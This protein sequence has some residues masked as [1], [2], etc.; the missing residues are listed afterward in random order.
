MPEKEK[1]KVQ[2]VTLPEEALRGVQ[3][4]ELRAP[5]SLGWLNTHFGTNLDQLGAN[6]V[7][8][9][10]WSD[11]DILR[12]EQYINKWNSILYTNF[13]LQPFKGET[14]VDRKG[15]AITTTHSEDGV[16]YLNR[17]GINYMYCLDV[18]VAHEIGHYLELKE[19][20][21]KDSEEMRRFR[22]TYRN[23]GLMSHSTSS[24]KVL[25][26]PSDISTGQDS[27]VR[28][29]LDGL[30]EQIG[31]NFRQINCDTIAFQKRKQAGLEL[32]DLANQYLTYI[33]LEE[34]SIDRDISKGG[35]VRIGHVPAVA[36][37]AAGA[38]SMSILASEIIHDNQLAERAKESYESFVETLKDREKAELS[39]DELHA[40]EIIIRAYKD[41]FIDS[42]GIREL[43]KEQPMEPHLER[44]DPNKT[45]NPLTRSNELLLLGHMR[46]ERFTDAIIGCLDH[47]GGGVVLYALWTLGEIGNKKSIDAIV[48]RFKDTNKEVRI[49]ALGSWG[50]AIEANPGNQDI[51]GHLPKVVELFDDHDSDLRWFS[52]D[53]WRS[54]V[55]ANPGNEE[56]LKHLPKLFEHF[57]D[58][59]L[60]V[61]TFADS[62]WRTALDVNSKNGMTLEY[63]PRLVKRFD[64]PDPNV[65]TSALNAWGTAAELN[66]GSRDILD[67]LPEVVKHF[68]D[69]NPDIQRRALWAWWDVAKANPGNKGVL[70]YIP[71]LVEHFNNPLHWM[72]SDALTIYEHAVEINPSNE[73]V[74]KHV[75]KAVECFNSPES[76]VRICALNVWN[77]ATKANPEN[78]EILR[79]VSRVVELFNDTDD[80]VRKT[81]LYAWKAAAKSNPRSENVLRHLPNVLE[82]FNDPD[83]S[84]REIALSAWNTAAKTSP[85]NE[86]VLRGVPKVIE[87]FTNP[88]MKD[89]LRS[90]YAI[91]VSPGYEALSALEFVG[92]RNPNSEEILNCLNS[93]VGLFDDLHP[94]VRGT[95]ISIW[96]YVAE[97]NPNDPRILR[98]RYA[99]EAA[100]KRVESRE[101]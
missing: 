70:E 61:Q 99:Y 50:R 38:W 57:N 59:S 60:V 67:C 29:V 63:L 94:D 56:V 69:P 9:Q 30:D 25:I 42:L 84:L 35:I 77:I 4:R 20:R 83:P 10:G 95:A 92:K 32:E 51:L 58:T 53:V 79:G 47:K 39:V 7:Q 87:L 13:W 88:E 6:T 1:P 78:E 19:G 66:P 100:K 8:T 62:A 71:D 46:D 43:F 52:I 72:Q 96:K 86:E 68:R 3:P 80:G 11:Q 2:K 41:H 54:A 14:E 101:D 40:T 76:Y 93:L 21:F 48:K 82:F 89:R 16:L 91:G 37:L 65:Q 26:P 73:E 31:Y 34:E 5:V 45:P 75:P 28:N 33:E 18:F 15:R 23:P 97:S 55:Q 17:T 90:T 12:L 85:N 74:L 36:R 64:D 44:L 49:W 81:A 24:E 98:T 27:N 22:N